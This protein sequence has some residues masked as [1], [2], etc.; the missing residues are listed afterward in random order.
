MFA[1]G[2]FCHVSILTA[3][4]FL[5]LVTSSHSNE[6]QSLMKF[7]SFVQ[8]SNANVFSSWTQ[9]NSPCHFN[10]IVCNS[11]GFV[12]A[13]NLA[14][15]QLVGTLPFDSICEL[16]SLEKISLESNYLHGVVSEELRKCT[17]LKYLDLGGNSFTGAVPDLSPLNKLEYLNLNASGISGAFPWKSLENLTSLTFL[18]LGDNLL[19]KNPFPLEVLKLEKLY[20]LY[21]TNCSITGNI[22]LGIGNLTQLQNLELSD[23]YLS[24]EIPADIG[25]LQRLWQLELY[26]NNLSGKIPVGFGN[27][28]NL[29]YFDASSNHLEGDLSEL[30]SLTNLASLQLFW[31]QFSGEV[32]KELGDLKNL[33]ELSLYSNNLIGP[34]PQKL[35]SWVGMQFIDVSDNSLSGPIPPH[36][37]NNNQITEL[38]LLNNSFNGTIPETYANCTSLARFRLSRNSLSGV[39][40]SGIWGL[41][42]LEL[43]D[44]KMNKFEGR[45]SSDIAKAKSLAQL[46]LSENQFSGELPLEIS[47]A[48][49]LVSIQL[50]SNQISG[51]IPET[52]GKLKKLTSLALNENNISGI[53]PDSIGSCTSLNE[54]NLA[55]NSLSGAIPASIG[56]LPTLNSLN[57]SSNRLSGEI[58]SSLSSLRL[59][60]L[61][62]SNNQLFGSIPESLA[63]SAFKDGFMGNPG[64]C[65]QT[66]K[67]FRPCSLESGSSRR[68][69]NLVVCFIAVLVVLF[70]SSAC[71]LFRKLRQSKFEKPLK[72]N[73]W[74]V[75]QYHVI[76]FN[77]NEI[78]DGIKAENL[79]GKGGSGNVYRVV[80]KSGEEFAVKHIWTSNPSDRGNCRSTSAML[81][82]SSRSPEYD[83]EVAT[84][85]SIRHVNVVK[86]YCSITSEDSSLLVYEFLPNG[87]LWD[88]L[89]TC[90]KTQMGWDI[91]YDIAMGAA[92]G[93]EY[94]HHGCAGPVIHRDVK[95]SNILLD[96]QWKPRIAD[97]GLAKIVQGGAGNWTH[98]IAG[99]LGYM[100][101]EYAYTCKVTEKSDVYS[102]GVVLME[103]VT[104][105]RPM[106][107]EFGE[108][109]DIVYWVCSNFRDKENALKLV[110]PAIGKHFKEDAMKVLRIATL[111]TAKIPASRPSMR[112]LVQML[113]EADPCTSAAKKIV[114]MDG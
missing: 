40:P 76:N 42:K 7:K 107:P 45:V 114:T 105:K 63:I 77:E 10:G 79:I 44:L 56:S 25:K 92:R 72:T 20:W 73:S 82:R 35:G 13:I 102:F 26:E 18:S 90:K 14:Q 74:N 52:I 62:L 11:K 98:V 33:T 85:S 65:S 89:H 19:E 66:L 21:L 61:D 27:L 46:F 95:S 94:L 6:L 16:Q 8:T 67:N 97:F 71:F 96:E 54:I 88:R 64:L 43:L 86:L 103:L 113:E 36:L 57:L 53:L 83:A 55:G 48:S 32:P 81:R 110:D 3:L 34:L 99:T 1:G 75:K 51:H 23:N 5:C 12:S 87:S 59:S 58:P 2:I 111:C 68:L 104:G 70:I 15:K 100:A 28:T 31:N 39:V 109:K 22:P 91:R 24:G 4:F 78:I 30:R 84:L 41:P 69:R 47:K 112:M 9:A 60:L 108:N 50:S 38:A 17:N 29:V 49:S 93:L 37:C 101:P 106:E 80:L